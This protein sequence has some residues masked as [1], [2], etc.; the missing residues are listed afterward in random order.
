MG[1]LDEN[2]SG[3]R[4][5][6]STADAAQM[7]VR[8]NE[9]VVD[10]RKRMN[11]QGNVV[12]EDERPVA[13][14]LDLRKAY[15][16][17][18]K[19]ALWLLLERYGMKGKCLDTIKDLHETT[20]YRVKG[21]EGMSE[22]WVPE[23]GLREGCATSPI[24]FN[25]FHQA[26][27]RQA[28]SERDV[29]AGVVWKWMPG[30]SFAGVRNW[31][32]KSTEA[33]EI[34]VRSVLFADDTTIVG[35]KEEM[36]NGVGAVKEVMGRWEERNN[37]DKEEELEFGEEEAEEIRMLGSWIG[38]EADVKNRIKRANGVWWRVKGQL[39]GSRM[40]KKW[41]ARVVEMCVES[42]MLFDCQVRTWYK[43]DLKRMQ[44]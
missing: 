33:K 6:R 12:N 44:T 39:K 23:R 7:M 14:L 40:T 38:P 17:V 31:E 5:G 9:D 4:K 41:Q 35:R 37:E 43:K 22:S 26:V 27:M 20:E 21:K 28:E 15:P 32:R 8:M 24:L 16:R 36:E 11:A 3:F 18:S 2:Q 29:N 1:V 42:A 30:G 34:R 13:R 25:I 19:P 10:Y